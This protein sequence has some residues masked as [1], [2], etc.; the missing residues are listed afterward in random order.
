MQL[1][2]VWQNVAQIRERYGPDAA[3]EILALSQAKIFLGS[4]TDHHTRAELVELLGQ[5]QAPDHEERRGR[6]PDVLSAQALQR[7]SGGEGLLV[8]GEL[9]PVF[10]RQ[11]RSYADRHLRRLAGAPDPC[12]RGALTRDAPRAA[13]RR[14]APC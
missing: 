5:R 1:L 6:A 13:A 3:A 12:A 10:F 9:P 8:H 14:P 7:L 4:I 11:R 2:T